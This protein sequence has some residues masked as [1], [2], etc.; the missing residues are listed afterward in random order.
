MVD[1][2]TYYSIATPN[3]GQTIDFRLTPTDLNPVIC[4]ER[5]LLRDLYV[6]R[7]SSSVLHH[8]GVGVCNDLVLGEH[9]R[10]AMDG[11]DWPTGDAD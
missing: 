3:D 2:C 7:V 10:V 8:K 6:D 1:T 5:H 9:P 11:T 4:G